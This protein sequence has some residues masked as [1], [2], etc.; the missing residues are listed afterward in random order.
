MQ[1]DR[2]QPRAARLL[3]TDLDKDLQKRLN[4]SD[5]E[6]TAL[7]AG[8]SRGGARPAARVNAS[9]G[10]TRSYLEGTVVPVLREAM[11]ELARKRPEDPFD[12]LIEY[13]KRNKPHHLGRR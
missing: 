5:L 6:R 1:Q 12:F 2:G 9:V 7:G 8:G 3:E 4:M 13:L 11:K 10:G